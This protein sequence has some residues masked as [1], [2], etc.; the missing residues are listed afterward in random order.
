[1]SKSSLDHLIEEDDEEDEIPFQSILCG[2]GAIISPAVGAIAGGIYNGLQGAGEGFVIGLGTSVGL[3]G[4][5]Y[6]F[7]AFSDYD[8]PD[9]MTF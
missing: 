6:V 4:L 5:G 7:Y 8:K 1:M 2:V 9:D 3:L